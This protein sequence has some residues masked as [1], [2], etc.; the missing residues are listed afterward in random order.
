MGWFRNLRTMTKLMLGFGLCGAV[1]ALLGWVGLGN[2]RAINALL[3][4]RTA[5]RGAAMA[6]APRDDADA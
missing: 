4:A 2:M 3:A 5:D 6:S 1:M